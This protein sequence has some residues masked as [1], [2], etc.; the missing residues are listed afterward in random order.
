MPL[1][2]LEASH[3]TF[4]SLSR[5]SFRTWVADRT[6]TSLA[7]LA[8]QDSDPPHD[9]QT[10]LSPWKLHVRFPVS[11][12]KL[13][14]GWRTEKELLL[15]ALSLSQCASRGGQEYAMTAHVAVYSLG[16]PAKTKDDYS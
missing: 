7:E 8:T 12:Q 15:Q 4:E 9:H 3:R 16:N 2:C 14:Q 5:Q 10:L 1:L 13:K 6:S 11:L